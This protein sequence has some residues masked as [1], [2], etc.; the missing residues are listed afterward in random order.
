MADEI[1]EKWAEYF[2]AIG[3]PIRLGIIVILYG[4]ETLSGQR[5]LSF[6]Q[7]KNIVGIPSEVSLTYHLNQLRD[8]DL[9]RKEP[10][11]NEEGR[12]YPIYHTTNKAKE[13]LSDF[14]LTE[15]L[16]QYLEGRLLEKSS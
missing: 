2:K 8:V 16:H 5:C 6:T 3:N 4:S 14:G 13:L 10:Y 15:H 7:I 9:I 1:L 12:V 11:Q